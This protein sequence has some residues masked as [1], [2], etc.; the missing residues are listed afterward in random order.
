MYFFLSEQLCY[1]LLL[2]KTIYY[3]FSG[4]FNMG[5]AFPDGIFIGLSMI[6]DDKLDYSLLPEKIKYFVKYIPK[7]EHSETL[8]VHEF[9]HI[10]QLLIDKNF[11]KTTV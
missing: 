5:V 3:T 8:I 9:F 11:I 1:Q 10:F 6:Y 2:D 4:L 7:K